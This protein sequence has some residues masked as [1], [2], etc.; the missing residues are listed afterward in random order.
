MSSVADGLPSDKRL[1]AVVAISLGIGM[2]TLDTAIVNTALP[3]LAEG[4]GTD[5]ASVIWV[6]NAYQLA[7]IAA[8]LPFASLSDVVGHRRVFL[9]G[10]LVFVVASLFCGLAWSLP[11]LTAARVVQGLGA[12]A[13]MS[14]NIAL[15]RHI[16][17][18]KILGRGL[19]YNSLVVGLAF[20][21][22]PTAASAILSVATWHWLYLINLPLGALALWL[23]VRAIPVIPITGHAFDR[24]A[25]ILCAGLFALLGLIAVALLCGLLLI[26]RQAGHPAPMLAVDLFKRPLFTLS[27]LTAICAFSAQ[28]LA[29]VSLPF[30]LQTVLGH[31]Q[32]A[33]GFL[34]TPWPA[35]VAVMA[36]IAGRLADR[37]S[38]ALLCGIGLVMLSAGM[39][40]LATLGN[41]ASTFDIG[42]RMALC[43]AGFGFFQSP[44]LKAIMTS[45]PIARSGGASGIVATSRLMGQTLGASLVALCFHLSLSSGPQYA[46]WLGCGFALVGAVASGLR[47][48]QDGAKV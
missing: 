37:I 31:S 9:G 26:R 41:D 22:G 35:V 1:A 23:G 14:V 45:A 6:V 30:L 44:N 18:A 47:L 29:F 39:A 5:S 24:L 28:G 13:I 42:W 48:M 3:T 36:L 19:G 12:A 16:Y 40:S 46:L 38:L 10:L 7:T 4:I 2:A 43:G 21:L 27:A 32:V 8:V 20:T 33:T 15:L 17:P 11:T 25:A 34:M